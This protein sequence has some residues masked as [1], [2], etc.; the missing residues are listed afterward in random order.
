MAYTQKIWD[1]IKKEWAAGQISTTEISRNYGPTRGA[2]LARAKTEGWPLRGSLQD[3]VR[4]EIA[5]QMV[6][7]EL[8]EIDAKLTPDE[9]V[10]AV[11]GAARRGLA[12][13]TTH[14]GLLS[15]LLDQVAVSLSETEN[16]AEITLDL[17]R[18]QR[19]KNRSRMVVD[20]SRAR[21]DSLDQISKILARA[22][23]LER[24]AF[25]LD[26]EKGE[27]TTIRYVAPD[28]KKPDNAGLG[29]DQDV[30]FEP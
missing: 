14:K 19:L 17:L 9:K 10:D 30:S 25:A 1:S 24:H 27:I 8:T 29:E 13:I 12:V 5:T 3:E 2:I 23:P 26:T 4:R 16:I 22:I 21:N 18:A 11:Q 6:D 15:R 20:M 7:Q 28:M